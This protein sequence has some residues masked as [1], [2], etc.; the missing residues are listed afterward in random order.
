MQ[1]IP[2]LMLDI[3]NPSEIF[4]VVDYRNHVEELEEW[5]NFIE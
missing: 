2:H 1:G 5:K 3:I 4:S